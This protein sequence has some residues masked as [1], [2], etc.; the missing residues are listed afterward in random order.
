MDFTR[1]QGAEWVSAENVIRPGVPHHDGS[2]AVIAGGDRPFETSV[3]ERVIFHFNGQA[4]LATTE[5][6]SFRDGPGL[7]DA[8]HL[9]AKVIMQVRGRMLLDD[10]AEPDIA[11]AR[12]HST[13]RFGRSAKIPLG[14]ILLS[15][16]KIFV[17][18]CNGWLDRLAP[19]G[20]SSL[21]QL[22]LPPM[23]MRSFFAVFAG[24]FQALL[25]H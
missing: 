10:K 20:S 17:S 19:N 5:R 1:A 15:P 4:P 2:S 12:A 21:L 11:A 9:Q 22:T 3:I 14:L 25:Q 7:E 16:M 24:F 6:K 23:R 13:S 8:L 18:G